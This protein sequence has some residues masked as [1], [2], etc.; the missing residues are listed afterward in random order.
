MIERT[1]DFEPYQLGVEEDAI[2]YTRATIQYAIEA[3]SV[4]ARPV[5]DTPVSDTRGTATGQS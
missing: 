2:D 5:S 3:P 4:D 1:P